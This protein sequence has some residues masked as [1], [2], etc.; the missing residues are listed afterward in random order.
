MIEHVITT[1][2]SVPG[3]ARIV[4]STEDPEIARC[5]QECGAEV[6]F[7]RPEELARDNTTLVH[8]LKH[9]LEALKAIGDRFDAVLSVPPT[10]PLLRPQTVSEMISKFHRT[11]CEAVA[12]VAE[13]RHGH[14][15]L[16]QT[17]KGYEGDIAEPL[18]QLP[19]G[20]LRYPRQ[21]R[22]S[23]YYYTG[24]AFLRDRSLFYPID[25]GTNCL[26]LKPRVVVVDAEEAI[27]IDD[28]TDFRIAEL[29]IQERTSLASH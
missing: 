6:P 1:L 5:A 8:V 7:R 14:P 29:L 17:L 26:G 16:C 25:P 10:A 20:A 15:Y 4:V 19:A 21:V 2:H 28:I 27:N 3:I 24:T 13:I 18:I 11:G 22:P 12:T 9:S 23:A